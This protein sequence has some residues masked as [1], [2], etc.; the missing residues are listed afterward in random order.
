MTFN[1]FP[2]SFFFLTA[3]C[4]KKKLTSKVLEVKEVIKCYTNSLLADIGQLDQSSQFKPSL[5]HLLEIQMKELSLFVPWLKSTPAFGVVIPYFHDV[6]VFKPCPC[7][8][9]TTLVVINTFIY[10]IILVPKKLVASWALFY[11]RLMEYIEAFDNSLFLHPT[12]SIYVFI[13]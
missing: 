10:F 12:Y 4:I 8:F 1:P 11:R 9:A 5:L 3:D 2:F 6:Q 7:D 13:C